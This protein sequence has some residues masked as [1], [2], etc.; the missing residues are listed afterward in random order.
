MHPS[1]LTQSLK[2]LLKK[3]AVFVGEDPK[4]SRKKIVSLSR[5]GCALLAR[6]SEGIG[7]I[8]AQTELIERSKGLSQGEGVAK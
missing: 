3:D 4:D 5:K 2:R 1:T 8:L 7:D 6:F